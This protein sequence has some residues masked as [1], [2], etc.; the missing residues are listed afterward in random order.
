MI[1][2]EI[3]ETAAYCE[4]NGIQYDLFDKEIAWLVVVVLAVI[5]ALL[6]FK[7]SA[8]ARK[9][10]EIQ[11]KIFRGYGLFVFG[12]A[13][14]RIPFIFSDI[15]RWNNCQTPLHA[16]FVLLSYCIGIFSSLFLLT[17]IER[18][19][20]GFKKLYLS[21][22]YFVLS[23]AATVMLLLLFVIDSIAIY[24]DQIRLIFMIISMF[25]I[26]VLLAIYAKLVK[27]TTG[28]IRK[29]AIITFLGIL[30]VFL[31]SILDG[32]LV[33]RTLNVPIWFPVIF[34]LIGFPTIYFS[35]IWSKGNE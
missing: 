11:M 19:L 25:G 34:P 3:N 1:S 9:I 2:I 15:E 30:L 13:M 22:S 29:K 26:A 8:N 20:V 6:F 32:E 16:Q 7:M 27:Q 24:L 10:S 31:G 23:I 5:C 28:F 18:D 14:S 4:G 33:I 21:K 35:Q 12:L 17:M